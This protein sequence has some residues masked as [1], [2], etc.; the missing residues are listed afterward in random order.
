MVYLGSLCVYVKPL[1][2]TA[3]INLLYYYNSIIT[4]SR[5]LT[6]PSNLSTENIKFT[7]RESR[8]LNIFVTR[9]FS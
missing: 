2:A 1:P 6:F 7:T 9:S 8:L 4:G 3:V 5:D